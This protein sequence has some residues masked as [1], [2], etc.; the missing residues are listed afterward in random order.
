MIHA[1]HF[2]AEWLRL[3]GLN[4]RAQTII[5][6]LTDYQST[7]NGGDGWLRVY[8]LDFD[9]NTFSFETYSPTLDRMRTTIDHYVE[10]I[11]LAYDQ[12][13]QIMEVLGATEEA[14]FQ[15]L[16]LFLKD[17]PAPDGFLL[18]HPDFDEPE[19]QAYYQQYLDDL[20]LGNPPPGFD[21]IL[22]WEGLWLEG[23][24]VDADDP[25]DF[26]D[27]VRSPSGSMVVDY[28][29]YVPEPPATA[30]TLAAFAALG[31]L[32]WFGRG[33]HRRTNPHPPQ[34]DSS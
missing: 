2:H 12:R 16:E 14:Y 22:E 3:D 33:S 25:L 28:T 19:E 1:G 9:E 15:I 34:E 20:F 30:G 7:R 10:T 18:Q 31:A 27:W 13:A 11:F 4:R 23:F 5:Q 17:R 6:I 24:A 8:E 21:D 32:G 29:A 26:R